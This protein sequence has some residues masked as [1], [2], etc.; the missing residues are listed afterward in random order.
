[1]ALTRRKH[2]EKL[3]SLIWQRRGSSWWWK[4]QQ[5]AGL[6]A[7][8]KTAI[9]MQS[10]KRAGHSLWEDIGIVKRCYAQALYQDCELA[11]ALAMQ[12]KLLESSCDSL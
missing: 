12:Q 8:W 6:V 4:K 5:K 1:M 7:V 2:L 11:K 10:A 9:S 3:F